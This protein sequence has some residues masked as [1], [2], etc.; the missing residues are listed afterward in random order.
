MAT[1]AHAGSAPPPGQ[2]PTS[3]P[4]SRPRP[5][6]SS[7]SSFLPSPSS[8]FAQALRAATHAQP[9]PHDE[10]TSVFLPSTPDSVDHLSWTAST[11]R[12]TRN[13]TLVRTYSFDDTHE[14]ITCATV[15]HFPAT[16]SVSPPTSTPT[17]SSSSRLFGPY[18]V[19]PSTTW[20]DGPLPL[21]RDPLPPQPGSSSSKPRSRSETQP[22]LLV[23]LST[24]A[25]AFPI[26]P[27]AG[28]APRS[29][30]GGRTPIA[31]PFRV[32]RA[33]AVDG[34]VL[35]ERAADR[36]GAHSPAWYTL[37]GVYDEFKPVELGED[38]GENEGQGG[39][40]D[41]GEQ[42][43][44]AALMTDA[45]ERLV[46]ASPQTAALPSPANAEEAL[47]TPTI[48]VS[49]N[50][51]ASRL[52]VWHYTPIPAPSRSP[53]PARASH[54][55]QPHPPASYPPS[56]SPTI[57][58]H[59]PL[60]GPSSATAP[61]T[62][63]ASM[64]R[65]PSGGTKRKIAAVAPDSPRG[66]P[67]ASSAT[68]LSHPAPDERSVRRISASLANGGTALAR[69]AS[70]SGPRPRA[71]L[72]PSLA[73]A[74]DAEA[75]LLLAASSSFLP[76]PS[77]SHPS[78]RPAGVDR[79]TS[80]S[81]N[82]LS[83]TMDRMALESLSQQSHASSVGAALGVGVE[84]R[85]REREWAWSAQEREDTFALPHLPPR[86]GE[87]EGWEELASE[88][89]SDG[90]VRK[91]W[92]M[93]LDGIG[94]ESLASLSAHLFDVRPSA[95]SATS[96]DKDSEPQHYAV[97]A[98]H[99]PHGAPV[100]PDGPLSLL[101]I[102][103]STTT[104]SPSAPSLPHVILHAQPL[105]SL[106]TPLRCVLTVRLSTTRGRTGVADL[107]LLNADGSLGL[108]GAEA[109]DVALPRGMPLRI[110]DAARLDGPPDGGTG[111]GKIVVMPSSDSGAAPRAV[112]MI[113][114]D[115]AG[116]DGRMDLGQTCLEA[117]A[118]VLSADD[119]AQVFE[120]VLAREREGGAGGTR[121]DALA[122]VLDEAFGR[123]VDVKGK[124]RE[125]AP[126]SAFDAFLERT[127]A[128]SSAVSTARD[129][130]TLLLRP[131]LS[132][133]APAPPHSATAT[134]PLT[135]TIPHIAIV[136]ALN[137]VKEDLI[138]RANPASR[139]DAR[140]VA[141]R[142]A[143][144]AARL[145]RPGWADAIGRELGF[146]AGGRRGE[147]DAAVAQPSDSPLLALIPTSPPS[148]L[149]YFSALLTQHS[150]PP[151]SL[152]TLPSIRA[153]LNLPPPSNFYGPASRPL[154]LST[155]VL[156][157]FTTLAP[158]PNPPDGL[159]PSP[160]ASV[161][162]SAPLWQTAL[163][164]A[165]AVVALLQTTLAPL[166][167]TLDDL[168]P[169]VALPLREA[170]RTAQLDSPLPGSEEARAAGWDAQRG[171][172]ESVGR[173][174][175]Q[176]LAE[177][178]A[179]QAA[180]PARVE[181]VSWVGSTDL[182]AIAK[183]ARDVA[184]GR[185]DAT[186]VSV[187]GEVEL[188]KE[189]LALP[190][191]K[192]VRFNED[193]RLDEVSRMVQFRE[194]VIVSAGERT[195]DQLTPSIQQN[196]LQALS[197]R[198]LA[199]PVGYG[200]FH[201]RTK[202]IASSSSDPIAIPPLT[203][204]ARILPMS[205]PV[206]LIEK[207]PR[208]PA[209][210]TATPP[211]GDRLEW[212]E[213]HAGVVAALQ[214]RLDGQAEALDASQLSFNRPADLDAR[215]AGLLLGLGL[216]GQLRLMLSSQAYDYLRAKHDPTSVGLLLGLAVSFL[217]T[218]DPTVT[219]VISIHLPALHPPRSSSLNVS[220]IIQSAA[221]VALGLV[222]FGTGRTSY[223]D[224]LL[225]ELCG[226]KVSQVED[227]GACREAYALSCGFG[228]GMVMLGKGRAQAG[229]TGRQQ[230]NNAAAAAAATKEVNLL[231]VFR[232]LILGPTSTTSTSSSSFSS[233]NAPTDTSITSP[234]ATVA[235]AL[236]Y[237]RSARADVADLF[238]LPDTPKAL[239]YVRHDLLLL[240][241]IARGLV[242]W[243]DVRKGRDWVDETLPPFLRSSASATTLAGPHKDDEE[244]AKYCIVAGACF[245]IGL[246]YAG[247]A[248]A[249]A[250][251]TLIYYLDK[252]TRLAFS[253]GSSVQA[254][255]KRNA[256]RGCL[257]AIAVAL[258]MVMAGTG[259]INV[260]RRLR[261]AHGVVT[262]GVGYGTH[263][264]THMALGLLLVGNG[265][266]TLG[267][268]DAAVAALLLSFYPAFPSDPKDNRG[269]LQAYRHLWVLA[270]E[271][272]YVEARDV[273]TDEPVFL[274]IRFRLNDQ[275]DSASAA[276]P[277]GLGV[278]A[279]SASGNK[280]DLRA[281]QMVA[282]TLIPDLAH[283]E[284][285]QIDS[286]RYWPYALHLASNSAHR[287]GFLAATPSTLYVKRR[288][289]HLSYAQDPRGI[290]SIF[291]RSK[292]ESGSTVFD[293]GEMARVL[294]PS[295]GS[296][297][298][299][300]VLAFSG[301]DVEA[302]ATTKMLCTPDDGSNTAPSA[303]EAF[304]A[305]AL[306]E[307][308]TKDKRDVVGV[309]HALYAAAAS[310]DPAVFLNP[311]LDDPGA[312]DLSL[313]AGQLRFVVNFYCGGAFRL[314]YSKPKPGAGSTATTSSSSGSGQVS[315]DPL[316]SPAL[317]EHLALRL[318]S[319]T[320]DLL[321][322]AAT[323]SDLHAYLS[324]LPS[325]PS[326]Q[327]SPSVSFL[328]SALRFPPHGALVQLRELVRRA[329]SE[330]GL[331]R[332]E[333]EVVLKAVGR[334]VFEAHGA[335]AIPSGSGAGRTAWEKEAE[336]AMLTAWV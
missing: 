297:L 177:G 320:S 163:S 38:R 334:K 328:L 198:T 90:R 311:V 244:I 233:A 71:S 101:L 222:H 61:S 293:F 2:P 191:A 58:R 80:T 213:F 149:A 88:R 29:A 187:P 313:D 153:A 54:T 199:L 197:H 28:P 141:E 111:D 66:P 267:N 232:A 3:P 194:P 242:F 31:L 256:L 92:E 329:V 188:G 331:S 239:D 81:R 146:G 237:L 230:A 169:A 202:S 78:R 56:S 34:G 284:S 20:S 255:M 258:A 14:H 148:L 159:P 245:V 112:R 248:A 130:L 65:A 12:W 277:S 257:G 326:A 265:Q 49:T 229:S 86:D 204:S 224:V 143:F 55:W 304:A 200:L 105:R 298:R 189:A 157:L 170:V 181:D 113:P 42:G 160:L 158:S 315:R 201:F 289:G 238:S 44:A 330:Q 225:R 52:T 203:T 109:R 18:T 172:W 75:S 127:V 45:D 205:S 321:A 270:V 214:L 217:A 51:R 323:A 83:V 46:F 5:R 118:D 291:T 186:K 317:I 269:H 253:R 241:T 264:A 155:A 193:K 17:S 30:P 125:K 107:L 271:P 318:A 166:N 9:Q 210:P 306:L 221:A 174:D 279:P 15:V 19:L 36:A 281:K 275:Y 115:R 114:S 240:R 135:P 296:G 282:P 212:P 305:S 16:S 292:S 184:E 303:F 268:S 299:D 47:P 22:T 102:R 57:T 73:T 137:L 41:G 142:V 108:L 259:E 302:L 133:A 94:R 266:Y 262:E 278:G 123:G 156:Q 89:R 218:S 175:L 48:L 195:I 50:A 136:L 6:P 104:T 35:V 276:V 219:S 236:M 274:P 263:L 68:T 290:R 10:P 27:P 314:L 206:P 173:G 67:A 161:A 32:R 122:G 77:S 183:H 162:T 63:S 179:S 168:A 70:L 243:D 165:H 325:P 72:P 26:P 98:L 307:C 110:D 288:T 60:A 25:F 126:V 151:F 207:E 280:P 53:T 116:D 336:R 182:D 250:H 131:P 226:V 119:F 139:S 7:A 4:S 234:A 8:R 176:R 308:L 62:L 335:K 24:L 39:M 154:S 251:A 287:N 74:S 82:E 209:N 147:P 145:G 196:I 333:V 93:Q 152:L 100:S 185:A 79:R 37:G 310:L 252:V 283:I 223:A 76:S 144:W 324:D 132:S 220:G 43:G 1:G 254:R 300:F 97:L 261:V 246:K 167:L 138:L 129:P 178:G 40:R 231:R 294:S 23:F 64:T 121:W 295:S 150:S 312:A 164:R 96:S 285:L 91:V 272:R 332:A 273:D 215:H 120:A 11:L 260:L 327:P 235:L 228:F 319:L 95:R 21:P 69:S 249:E 13:G 87:E 85:E 216:T 124:G 227:V 99:F 128:P 309:Y 301:T 322:D 84:G 211:G 117:L 106:S 140:R 33:R 134:S 316:L 192:A 190:S 247:T 103:L 59:V 208:D 180:E 286:P 171:L